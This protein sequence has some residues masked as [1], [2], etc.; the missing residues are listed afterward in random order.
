MDS[1]KEVTFFGCV[2]KKLCFFMNDKT[3]DDV[4]GD[5]NRQTMK[6]TAFLILATVPLSACTRPENGK[7][8][9]G[10][11]RTG[12]FCRGRN[13]RYFRRCLLSKSPTWR[14]IGWIGEEPEEVTEMRGV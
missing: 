4:L 10:H 7:E 5:R 8:T 3:L 13:G 9:I 12:R 11:C 1:E 2:R 14:K 6:N